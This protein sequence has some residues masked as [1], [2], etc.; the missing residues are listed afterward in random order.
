[1]AYTAEYGGGEGG[2]KFSETAGVSDW[3]VSKKG[4]DIRL[5][6]KA[7]KD[8]YILYLSVSRLGYATLDVLCQNRQPMN[9][10]GIVRAV[11]AKTE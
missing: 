4:Y 2:I 3:Q 8:I 6:V 10:T 9:F 11:P 5:E 7:P 1:V